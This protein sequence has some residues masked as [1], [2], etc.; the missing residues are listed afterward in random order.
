M[1]TMH[2][3]RSIVKK[4]FS[5]MIFCTVC[6]F[7][8]ILT[9]SY[10]HSLTASAVSGEAHNAKSLSAEASFIRNIEHF[11]VQ[12]SE[13]P[14]SKHN[15]SPAADEGTDRPA[16]FRDSGLCANPKAS[17]DLKEYIKA[18]PQALTDFGLNSDP[19]EK[20]SVVMPI[21]SVGKTPLSFTISVDSKCRIDIGSGGSLP[22][23]VNIIS[24][25]RNNNTLT[26]RVSFM[27]AGVYS[28]SDIYL[29]FSYTVYGED[30]AE[31][32]RERIALADVHG[33]EGNNVFPQTVLIDEGM[34]VRIN[35]KISVG[36]QRKNASVKKIDS[37]FLVPHENPDPAVNKT[38]HKAFRQRL[39]I[40]Q[41][42]L[43]NPADQDGKPV[44]SV[45]ILSARKG[46]KESPICVVT[47]ETSANA[48]LECALDDTARGLLSH[49]GSYIF[50]PLH[51]LPQQKDAGDPQKKV[52]TLSKDA[53]LSGI[54]SNI[55]V[56]ADS[57][58]PSIGRLELH[59]NAS[60]KGQ[61][62][63]AGSAIS[64]VFSDISDNGVGVDWNSASAWV[65]TSGGPKGC[66]GIGWYK[67]SAKKLDS[68]IVK[69]VEAAGSISLDIGEDNQRLDLSRTG[70]AISDKNG[71]TYFTGA[72]SEW[73]SN[74]NNSLF[75]KEKIA[76]DTEAPKISIT[77]EDNNSPVNGK[78]YKGKRS[79]TV[80]VTD[81]TL[82]I[83][84]DINAEF[85]VVSYT[86][87]GQ[88]KSLAAGQLK[89][90]NNIPGR[91]FAVFS[92][93]SDGDWAYT[94]Q[95]TDIAGHK[96]DTIA[97]KFIIDSSKPSANIAFDN[98]SA[99][100]GKYYKSRR[101][102][103]I[104][105]ADR[106]LDKNSSQVIVTAISKDGG[107]QETRYDAQWKETFEGSG[108][109]QVLIPFGSDGEYA[110]SV[111]AVDMAGNTSG[112]VQSPSFIID[113][114]APR[115]D[116]AG[117]R[118]NTAYAGNV[119]SHIIYSDDYAN[120]NEA[121]YTLTGARHGVLKNI[122]W[123]RQQQGDNLVLDMPDLAH[124]PDNDD[125][126]TLVVTL[127]DYAGNTTTKTVVFSVNRFGSTY[128]FTK[129]MQNIRGKYLKTAPLVEITEINVSGLK[130]ETES[131][132]IV[133]DNTVVNFTGKQLDTTHAKESGWSKT[134]YRL[135]R[136]HFTSDGYYRI[137]VRSIDDAG[138]LSQNSMAKKG[139][140]RKSTATVQFA[141]DT[142]DPYISAM[143]IA[144]DSVYYGFTKKVV[145]HASDNV[146][147]SKAV[148]E[149]DN[150]P[151][152]SYT[153]ESLARDNST[154]LL[155]ADSSP[156]KVTVK[157]WDAAGNMYLN[158]YSNITVAKDYWDYITHNQWM[159]LLLIVGSAFAVVLTAMVAVLLR[160]RRKEYIYKRNPF[161][162]IK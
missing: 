154:V 86:H 124:T 11:A 159:L 24:E 132:R 130:P 78:F 28:F 109:W 88:E 20:S 75:G 151:Y 106:Y 1:N 44:D 12:K 103:M 91:Y 111:I 71:N 54:S 57:A 50:I 150:R 101:M 26:Y 90:D 23:G 97:D 82:D 31:E 30:G 25:G 95:I 46:D 67:N 3:H 156:H 73:G 142:T 87:D 127:T 115:I 70:L 141:V 6:A 40:I 69:H 58:A 13:S 16:D 100:N 134:T 83:L 102:A 76:V 52:D 121:R 144:S 49:D 33:P 9:G 99:L 138:N 10:G 36:E 160:R 39:D 72:L 155:P 42:A 17:F 157:A 112:R 59:G 21:T 79:F 119:G 104:A 125:V 147:L 96:G 48:K 7:G 2:D 18:N 47:R 93:D 145:I 152:C 80:T 126:Y 123:V 74:E 68:V 19:I 62:L 85:P 5:V 158:T 51:G 113:T 108:I 15:L 149:I 4:F 66:N 60:Q 128:I 162:Y 22:D 148:V 77:T 38:N 94:A 120:M 35:D 105:V 117:I 29:T 34:D 89:K 56:I 139:I 81:S 140:D 133:H 143:N 131:V 153:G 63:V 98:N 135:S 43:K 146:K 92:A 122:K 27:K 161:M 61:W 118:N 32:K 116:I 45:P 84:Q 107:R 65:C 136:S 41:K 64:L 8:A 137:L 114:A 14:A 53:S 129:D 55:S 110:V 37:I